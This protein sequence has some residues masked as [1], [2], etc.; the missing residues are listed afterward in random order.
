MKVW[1]LEPLER[2]GV[3]TLYTLYTLGFFSYSIFVTILRLNNSLYIFYFK[4]IKCI[5]LEL[6][7]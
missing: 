2:Q 4:C 1:E 3:Y 5:E 6:K 7:P